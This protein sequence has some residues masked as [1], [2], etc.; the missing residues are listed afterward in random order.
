MTFAKT[1]KIADYSRDG[2]AFYNGATVNVDTPTEAI[3]Y[4][5]VDPMRVKHNGKQDFGRSR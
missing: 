4:F 3:P 2:P 1:T 5:D